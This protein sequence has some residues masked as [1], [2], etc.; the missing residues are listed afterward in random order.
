MYDAGLDLHRTC[1]TL[2]VVTSEGQ[3]VRDHQRQPAD[4]R[5]DDEW[6]LQPLLGLAGAAARISVAPVQAGRAS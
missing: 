4:R 2:R 5:R 6:L 3:V 1:F